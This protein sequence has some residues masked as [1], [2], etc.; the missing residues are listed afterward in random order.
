MSRESLWLIAFLIMLVA[1]VWLAI[2]YVLRE[3][4]LLDIA[5][6]EIWGD[7]DDDTGEYELLNWPADLADGEAE[8]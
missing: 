4:E 5:N 1:F 7:Y 2:E 6:E 3:S 8:S